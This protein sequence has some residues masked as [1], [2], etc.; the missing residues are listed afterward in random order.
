MD[1]R[2]IETAP[3]DEMVIGYEDGMMRLVLWEGEWKCVGADVRPF[4]F[5]PTHWMPL[6]TA[7]R[8]DE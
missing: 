7:P 5:N 6:P 1:W 2:P 3:K 4:W 8:K